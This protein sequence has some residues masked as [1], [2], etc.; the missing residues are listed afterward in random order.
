MEGCINIRN[1]SGGLTLFMCNSSDL[2]NITIIHSPSP[3]PPPW[4]VQYAP[5]L[6]VV[7]ILASLGVLMYL[8]PRFRE[9][10][11]KILDAITI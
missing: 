4:Y 5:E 3:P 8:S 6:A 7:A 10:V 9:A 11:L 2:Q 1:A